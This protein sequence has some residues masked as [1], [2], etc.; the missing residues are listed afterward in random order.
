MDTLNLEK[1]LKEDSFFDEAAVMESKVPDIHILINKYIAE[2]GLS[3]ATVIRKLNVERSYGYQ[4]LNG[5]RVP[6]RT[7]IIKLGLIFKLE[8]DEMQRLLK[9]AGKGILYARNYN[10]AKIIYAIEHKF[11]YDK[12]CEFALEE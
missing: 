1:K 3:H 8:L 11:D 5:N 6:T 10:D 9:A 12:A 4:L 2:K 7:H